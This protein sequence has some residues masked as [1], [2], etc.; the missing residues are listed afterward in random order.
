MEELQISLTPAQVE[1]KISVSGFVPQ[2]GQV[3][4]AVVADR[5]PS[6]EMVLR[7]GAERVTASA[8]IPY[9]PAPGCFW[10]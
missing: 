3:L 8:D 9:N 10:K 6:G 1:Q 2:A 5:L 7:V 4:N